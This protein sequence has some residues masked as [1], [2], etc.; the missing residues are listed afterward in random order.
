MIC[1]HSFTPYLHGLFRPW[2]VGVLWDKDARLPL[3]LMAALR[4]SSGVCVGDNM[5]YSGRHDADF[6]IDHHAEPAGLAHAGIE[7][8]QDLI[9]DPQGQGRWAQ[10]IAEALELVLKREDLYRSR[11]G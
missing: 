10:T 6:T 4:A 11:V 1:I 2:E 5:P 3:P 8:R 9:S 7:I